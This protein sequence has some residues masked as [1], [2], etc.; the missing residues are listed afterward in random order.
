MTTVHSRYCAFALHPGTC[1]N[2]Q[3]MHEFHPGHPDQDV[4]GRRGPRFGRGG[5]SGLFKK[6]LTGDKDTPD[7]DIET[8]AFDFGDDK[9][10]DWSTWDPQTEEYSFQLEAP[11]RP[12]TEEDEEEGEEEE[13]GLARLRLAP[14]DF[15][16]VLSGIGAAMLRE[17]MLRN[18]IDADDPKAQFMAA[19]LESAAV[20][21]IDEWVSGGYD[22]ELGWF[23]NA[24]DGTWSISAKDDDGDTVGFEATD[25]QMRKWHAAMT[26]HQIEMRRGAGRQTADADVFMREGNLITVE[27][28]RGGKFAKKGAAA[29]DAAIAAATPDALAGFK[30]PAL[31]KALRDRG[32]KAAR[33]A[34]DDELR[35]TLLASRSPATAAPSVPPQQDPTRQAFTRL[36]AWHGDGNKIINSGEDRALRA[37]RERGFTVVE[38]RGRSTDWVGPDG[39]KITTSSVVDRGDPRIEFFE[40]NFGER[41]LTARQ[42][43]D[44]VKG[45]VRPTKRAPSTPAKTRGGKLLQHEVDGIGEQMREAIA[46]PMPS[47]RERLKAALGRLTV[48]QLAQVA[49]FNDLQMPGG[50]SARTKADKINRLVENAVGSRLNSD[51]IR[52]G[53]WTDGP[54]TPDPRITQIRERMRE[55]DESGDRG[56]YHRARHDLVNMQRG[57]ETDPAPFR[58]TREQAVDAGE[59]DAAP[60]P[61]PTSLDKTINQMR[62]RLAT[63]ER[64]YQRRQFGPDGRQKMLRDATDLGMER[65]IAGLQAQIRDAETLKRQTGGRSVND[66]RPSNMDMTVD[67]P[68]ES[69]VDVA[70]R[71]STANSEQDIRDILDTVPNEQLD[72]VMKEVGVRAR[73]GMSPADKRYHIARSLWA[74]RPAP[75]EPRRRRATPTPMRPTKD[76]HA[77]RAFAEQ[78]IEIEEMAAAGAS[79]RAFVHRLRGRMKRLKLH[80]VD[81][82]DGIVSYVWKRAGVDV[83]LQ[84]GQGSDDDDLAAA[85]QLAKI[86]I[87]A[88]T[89]ARSGASPDQIVEHVRGEQAA[90]GLT[91]TARAGEIVR[92]DPNLHRSTS[93]TAA[94]GTPMRVT[95]PGYRWTPPE[96]AGPDVKPALVERAQVYHAD[97]LV[98][99]DPETAA[100]VRQAAIDDARARAEVIAELVETTLNGADPAVKAR[101]V[102][103][104]AARGS[105]GIDPPVVALVEA[106]RINDLDGI[107]RGRADLEEKYGL[108]PIGVQRQQIF[109]PKMH[110]M[111]EGA[112]RARA[113]QRVDLVRPGFFTTV[114][115]ERIQLSKAVVE[116]ERPEDDDEDFDGLPTDAT[117]APAVPPGR[118][119]ST[120]PIVE[121]TWG[122][123]VTEVH[124]HDD[125]EIG[126]AIRRMGPDA[127]LEVEGDALA[128]VLGRTATD[129]VMGRITAVQQLDRLKE[130]A[131]KLPEGNGKMALGQAIRELDFPALPG[132]Q[133]MNPLP[134]DTPAPMRP[135][136][137]TL[138]SALAQIPLAHRAVNRRDGATE[139]DK[140]NDLVADLVAGRGRSGGMQFIDRV[141]QVAWNQRHESQEGKFEI[142]RAVLAAVA[143]LEQLIRDPAGRPAFYPQRPEQ[144]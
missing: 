30:R 33:G 18:P 103:A 3:V 52:H 53:Q 26:L 58:P 132:E 108:D 144:Q 72:P 28:G 121:N 14:A 106:I 48:D 8:E 74:F 29:I 20:M 85:Q 15:D 102:A 67:V 94:A 127:R 2:A 128:N 50:A 34:P 112:P 63:L 124:F 45:A 95:A 69:T 6:I 130:I 56:A 134:S 27:R 90:Q 93:G 65:E 137:E 116:P 89:M 64:Q 96:D 111:I 38:S 60:A 136:L 141:R 73:A 126:Q 119:M 19:M 129:L 22:Q 71:I 68:S 17:E 80:P 139:M 99:P 4:H 46:A 109:D 131:S 9:T 83:P 40:D 57:V 31:L 42:A 21:G 36:Y 24:K 117:P 76:M 55:A 1:F 143:A 51:A 11:P 91:P 75:P 12:L 79:E 39:T 23:Y 101:L 118:V 62:R 10:V 16:R 5:L 32:L 105:I 113:G 142:D 88:E 82:P 43:L 115:G 84:P 13:S 37:M 120:K 7:D 92:F 125:G 107:I 97:S 104:A 86:A 100:R 47:D 59:V 87:A 54:G 78:A 49:D 138:R 114:N 41:P 77:A 135:V 25:E 123:R 35:N 61:K 110:Q 122:G 70:N 81:N 133:G 98:D 66:R 44:H 140:I